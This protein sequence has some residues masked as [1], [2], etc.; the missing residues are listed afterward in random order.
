MLWI[1]NAPAPVGLIPPPGDLWVFAYGSLMW[2]PGFPVDAI[3]SAT[4]EGWHRAFCVSSVGHRGTPEWPGLVVGLLPGGCCH[5]LALRADP[6][7][8]D[9]TLDYLWRR[10]LVLADG[11]AAQVVTCTAHG[12]CEAL[13]FVADDG[14][15]AFAGMLDAEGAARRIATAQGRRGSNRDYLERTIER[16]TALGIADPDVESV[17]H[18]VAALAA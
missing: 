8:R 6:R 7:H 2:D 14:H 16:L 3:E 1:E 15:E 18:A 5:G 12:D 9:A 10:E 4:L 13:T 11:Y 17:G